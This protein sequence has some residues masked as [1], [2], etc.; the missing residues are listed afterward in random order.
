MLV[1]CQFEKGGSR[2]KFVINV[3]TTQNCSAAC[4][5]SMCF[6]KVKQINLKYKIFLEFLFMQF[7]YQC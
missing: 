4:S 6:E 2:N 3:I 7:Y 1:L 5:F